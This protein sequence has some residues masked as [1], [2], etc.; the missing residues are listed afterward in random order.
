MS[1]HKEAGEV[2]GQLID[3]GCREAIACVQAADKTR[4]KEQRAVVVYGGIADI[5][6]HAMAAVLRLNA[7]EV[8]GYFVKSFVP[9]DLLPA[10]VG[11]AYRVFE[12]I[13]IV[14]NVLKRNR[15]RADV[16]T[17]E[18]VIRIALDTQRSVCLH[19]DL[20]AAHRLA[21]IASAEM[22]RRFLNCFHDR[23]TRKHKRH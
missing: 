17:T 15:F 1:E 9:A 6:G 10:A 4:K 16:A 7:F 21:K 5:R 22:P 18:D 13:F 23:A 12:S 8:F 11:P 20:D 2:M 3:R 14:V 19:A